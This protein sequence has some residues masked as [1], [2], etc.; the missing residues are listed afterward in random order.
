MSSLY[1]EARV[2]R[3]Q[4]LEGKAPKSVLELDRKDISI[5]AGAD[6]IACLDKLY[7][8]DKAQIAHEAYE[9]FEKYRRPNV[10]FYEFQR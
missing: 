9:I 3:F 4:S 7:L 2:G 10:R 6:N 8:K 5:C 1:N